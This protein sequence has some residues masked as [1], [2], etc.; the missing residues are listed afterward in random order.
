MTP[1][2]EQHPPAKFTTL[3][4]EQQR[5]AK[6]LRQ[7][8]EQ[9]PNLAAEVYAGR[10]LEQKSAAA[11]I[12]SGYRLWALDALQEDILA[13]TGKGSAAMTGADW[14]D[15]QVARQVDG[16]GTGRFE[17]GVLTNDPSR[18]KEMSLRVLESS[19]VIYQAAHLRRL[20]AAGAEIHIR[21]KEL[22][23]Y[24][25]S[26]IDDVNEGTLARMK[27]EG[28]APA[29]VI[30]TSPDNY[31]AWMRHSEPLTGE[32][33]YAA[34]KALAEKFGSDIGA[35]PAGH[36]GRLAGTTNRKEKYETV[37]GKFPWVVVTEASGK[38]YEAAPE[39]VAGVK[40]RLAIE[41]KQR[42][43]WYQNRET[44]AGRSAENLK[45]IEDF[46][47]DLRYGGDGHRVD[48]AYAMYARTKGIDRADV[49]AAIE[50]RDLSHKAK[51]Y[52]EYTIRR[53]EQKISP[54]TPAQTNSVGFS[55]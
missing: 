7:F 34:G 49:A 31:Q 52:V 35:A 11:S 51:N 45:T 42:N 10:E 55:F 4:N 22:S 5:S 3:R 6:I 32:A 20:N 54:S 18:G 30:R 29:V 13:R 16:M 26:L 39:F 8:V 33:S 17:V 46:R 12:A 14:A 41:L 24:S 21:P 37:E 36:M 2:N 47:Q 25:L 44:V 23:G 50:T 38:V 40:E 19:E 1:E 43:E 53:A 28:F 48:F 15:I 27:S 9:H